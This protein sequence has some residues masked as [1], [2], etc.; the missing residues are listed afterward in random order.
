MNIDSKENIGKKVFFINRS[1]NIV[2]PNEDNMFMVPNHKKSGDY[3]KNPCLYLLRN[4]LLLLGKWI[5][6]KC[7]M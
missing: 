4:K 1:I 3:N 6:E 2:Y 5:E 7:S